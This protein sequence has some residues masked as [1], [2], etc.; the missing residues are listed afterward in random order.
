MTL[1]VRDEADII[2][3]N[4]DYHLAQGV[5]AIIVTDHGSTR[6]HNRN[7]RKLCARPGRTRDS[8]TRRS[9]ITRAVA[10]PRWQSLPASAFAADWIIHTDADE[11]WW[12]GR[13][14]A[15]RRLRCDPGRVWR[16]TGM[17]SLQLPA[18]ARRRSGPSRTGLSY[19]T[20]S[21][22][23]GSGNPLEPKV[24]P[25]PRPG[26]RHR[27]RQSLLVGGTLKQLPHADM[28]E[29]FIFR[30]AVGRS[31]SAR[32]SSLGTATSKLDRSHQR[33]ARDQLAMLEIHRRGELAQRYA[34]MIPA[35]EQLAHGLEEKRYV[36]DRRLQQF[37]A[38]I[39]GLAPGE[40]P[41]C[42]RG[43]AGDSRSRCGGVRCR[44]G[45]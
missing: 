30:P 28:L 43:R 44:A 9:G 12:A 19:A 5:D 31:S 3:A 13:R 20:R 7:S 45:G 21:L 41:A 10:S 4:L 33:S 27:S 1:V 23:T 2:A 38:E 22:S 39:A 24:A 37:L 34:Y 8:A 15:A 35:P 14:L 36:V 17:A 26:R 11:F 6:R 18:S 16:A 40:R 29:I 42:P 25:P 32:S